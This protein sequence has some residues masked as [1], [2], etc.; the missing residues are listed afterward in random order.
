MDFFEAE[1]R[2]SDADD[3]MGGWVHERDCCFGPC[4]GTGAGQ[5]FA[6]LSLSPMERSYLRMKRILRS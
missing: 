5:F 4:L 1:G 3:S 2:N 6:P